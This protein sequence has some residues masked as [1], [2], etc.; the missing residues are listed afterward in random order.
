[1]LFFLSE[2]D[3]QEFLEKTLN[4]C[5]GHA[6]LCAC[7][8]WVWNTKGS[9]KHPHQ[10]ILQEHWAPYWLQ[11][12]F[13]ICSTKLHKDMFACIPWIEEHDMLPNLFIFILI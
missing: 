1:M 5:H 10:A 2:K 12:P 6:W 3:F 8:F 4:S 7:V 11:I 13:E 9:W